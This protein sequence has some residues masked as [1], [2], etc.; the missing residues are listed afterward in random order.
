MYF[1]KIE[2]INTDLKTVLSSF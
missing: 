2:I 1:Y